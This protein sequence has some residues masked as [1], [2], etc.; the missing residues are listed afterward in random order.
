[1]LVAAA[2]VLALLLGA[3]RAL[4]VPTPCTTSW[5]GTNG[6]WNNPGSWDNG[7]PDSNDVACVQK[8]GTYQ[9]DIVPQDGAVANGTPL[10]V[11]KPKP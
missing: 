8:D 2:A 11:K 7:V 1:M 3:Q 4:A 10:T 9:I 5:T 6:P